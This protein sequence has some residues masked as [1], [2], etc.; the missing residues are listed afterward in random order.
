MRK[1]LVDEAYVVMCLFNADS[2]EPLVIQR[3]SN[4]EFT[5][6][7]SKEGGVKQKSSD[8]HEDL[9][10]QWLYS[11]NPH[12]LLNT[13]FPP[14]MQVPVMKNSNWSYVHGR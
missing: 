5:A 7:E 11:L 4:P 3:R 9:E 12:H 10:S 1:T 2:D 6:S 8:P 13:S 14:P